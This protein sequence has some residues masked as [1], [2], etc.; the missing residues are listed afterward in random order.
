M[1]KHY[2]AMYVVKFI[3]KLD[4]N[5]IAEDEIMNLINVVYKHPFVALNCS[6]RYYCL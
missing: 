6:G 4:A 1:A 3:H 5:L 2:I